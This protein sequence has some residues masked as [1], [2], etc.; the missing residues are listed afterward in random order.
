MSNSFFLPGHPTK[1]LAYLLP[2]VTHIMDQ[3][4]I[5]PNVDGPIGLILTPTR[6]LSKQVHYIAKKI[7]H[8]VGGKAVSVTGT[9]SIN[10]DII[11]VQA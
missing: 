11:L 8:V 10:S 5:V 9:F 1:T 7:L 6:E 2:L 3:R 4:H